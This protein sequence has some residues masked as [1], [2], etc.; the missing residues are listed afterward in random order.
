MSK[1]SAKTFTGSINGFHLGGLK[2]IPDFILGKKFTELD[3][4][5]WISFM[6]LLH[7]KCLK[8]EDENKKLKSINKKLTKKS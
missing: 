7:T 1:N 4:D 6:C 8:L 2:M 3:A 5:E